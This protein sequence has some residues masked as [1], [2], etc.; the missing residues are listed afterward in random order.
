MKQDII[1]QELIIVETT[2]KINVI[3]SG[4]Y[5]MMDLVLPKGYQMDMFVY[6]LNIH[7]HI[8]HYLSN[9]CTN[10]TWEF[11]TFFLWVL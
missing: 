8:S 2:F 10:G 5:F 6:T 9:D 7:L 1:S 3:I 11:L 4:G